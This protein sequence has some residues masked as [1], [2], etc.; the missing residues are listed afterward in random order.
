MKINYNKKNVPDNE[1]I[2][3]TYK[4]EII[5]QGTKSP[6]SGGPAISK[7]E[8]KNRYNHVN[9][10]RTP[11]LQHRVKAYYFK[12]LIRAERRESLRAAV[13]L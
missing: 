3:R 6:I 7:S 10:I 11:H 13:F 9:L 12:A 8:P 2:H 5:V 1:N 4:K